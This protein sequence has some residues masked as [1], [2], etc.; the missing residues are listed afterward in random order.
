MLAD[1][2]TLAAAAPATANP[3]QVA[4]QKKVANYFPWNDG[5]NEDLIKFCNAFKVHKRTAGENLEIKFAKVA[6]ALNGR[7]KFSSLGTVTKD[8]AEC[9]YKSLKK[10]ITK[11]GAFSQEGANL[12]GLSDPEKWQLDLISMMQEVHN[13]KKESEEASEEK[14]KKEKVLVYREDGILG[15]DTFT[16]PMMN[17]KKEEGDGLG[18]VRTPDSVFSTESSTSSRKRPI[19]EVIVIDIDGPINKLVAAEISNMS[20]S[21][22]LMEAQTNAFTL[23][24]ESMRENTLMMRE[25]R[26]EQQ[27]K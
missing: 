12:S 4:A 27:R 11:K 16:A 18:E 19:D 5:H 8:A 1:P 9:K 23:M 10:E 17:V 6:E 2:P 3:R 26:A 24:A 7:V 21:R 13:T 14:K 22:E 15:K 20:K 25:W